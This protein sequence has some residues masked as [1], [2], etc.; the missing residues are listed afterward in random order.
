MLRII[1]FYFCL[2]CSTAVFSQRHKKDTVFL[3]KAKDQLVYI[4]PDI[5]SEKY[6][7]LADFSLAEYQK[8]SYDE[9]LRQ[10]ESAEFPFNK[11]SL[12]RFPRKWVTINL[13]QSKPYAYYPCDFINYSALVFTDSTLLQYSGEPP[14]IEPLLG[15]KRIDIQTFQVITTQRSMIF[16][17]ISLAGK[18]LFLVENNYD[19]A[20]QMDAAPLYQLMIPA[21]QIKTVPMIVNECNV[22][23]QL[24]WAFDN[25]NYQRLL[26]T[27]H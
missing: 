5:H 21:S 24:E 22:Q 9:Q 3:K 11:F 25:P 4:E 26:Q 27:T 14:Q 23:K 6:R 20:E 7:A 10:F 15:F 19:V 17:F 8:E 2:I 1:L 12:G 18:K 13:Y 16:H